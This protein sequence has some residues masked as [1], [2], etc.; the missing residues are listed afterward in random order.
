MSSVLRAF[1]IELCTY[2]LDNVLDA[3]EH[4]CVKANLK[5]DLDDD[6][7]VLK[8]LTASEVVEPEG[9]SNSEAVLLS[10]KDLIDL[11]T[12]THELSATY[13]WH[14]H[15]A[16][17]RRRRRCVGEVRRKMTE[18]EARTLSRRATFFTS[19][20]EKPGLSLATGVETIID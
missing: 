11:G 7:P 6:H 13:K 10:T 3:A 12:A 14:F 17:H 18:A 8:Y 2:L 1:E 15:P 5:A 19:V 20:L 9:Q 16:V 4:A